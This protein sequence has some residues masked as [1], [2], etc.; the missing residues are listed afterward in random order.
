ML[1][2]LP[3]QDLAPC[4]R[5][6]EMPNLNINLHPRAQLAEDTLPSI[7]YQGKL[8]TSSWKTSSRATSWSTNQTHHGSKHGNPPCIRRANPH[9]KDDLIKAPLR[10][11]SNQ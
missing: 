3:Q 8:C 7:S 5:K 2:I 1:I 10:S 4:T 9:G 11:I 6:T